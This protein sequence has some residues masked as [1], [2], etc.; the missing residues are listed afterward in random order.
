MLFIVALKNS[1]KVDCNLLE[2][3]E[4]LGAKE[5]N[6]YLSRIRI[7]EINLKFPDGDRPNISFCFPALH[8]SRLIQQSTL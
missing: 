5:E 2:G 1:D 7:H 3:W 6:T 4:I 8:S